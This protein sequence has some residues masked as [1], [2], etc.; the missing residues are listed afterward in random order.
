LKAREVKL[1]EKLN[2]IEPLLPSVRELQSAGITFDIIIPY[3]MVINEKSVLENVDLKAAAY[4]IVHSL[5][6]YRDLGSLRRAIEKAEQ[7]L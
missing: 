1:N 3:V 7:K 6:E 5:R 4:D 2:E